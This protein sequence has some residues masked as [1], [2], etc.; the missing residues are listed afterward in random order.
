MVRLQE[1]LVDTELADNKSFSLWRKWGW[2]S[3]DALHHIL[4]EL[5]E[6]ESHLEVYWAGLIA[7]A[8]QLDMILPL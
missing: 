1:T 4:H 8:H 7:R 2:V 6:P 5:Y 3:G